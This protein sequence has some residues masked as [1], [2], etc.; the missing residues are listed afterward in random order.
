MANKTMR[1][2]SGRGIEYAQYFGVVDKCPC[3]GLRGYMELWYSMLGSLVFS[4]KHHKYDKT[5]RRMVT[6]K[7]CWT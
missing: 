2:G 1:Y 5:L 6:S 7:R 3:C 4:I